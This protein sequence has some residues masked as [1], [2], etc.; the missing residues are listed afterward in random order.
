MGLTSD[1]KEWRD[2]ILGDVQRMTSNVAAGIRLGRVVDVVFV[3]G[4]PGTPLTVGAH[5][6]FR[7]GLNGPAT[8][9]SWAMG[10]TVVGV[11]T[12]GAITV[13]LLAGASLSSLAS[14]CGGAPP[15]LAGTVEQTEVLPTAA[16]TVALPDPSWLMASVTAAD[17]VL[18]EVG[19]TLRVSVDPRG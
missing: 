7:I 11:P 14:L 4:G 15:A 3:L 1:L 13:D 2:G 17:G 10:A 9:L 5:V 19:L 18:E 8:I 16:W 6:F 12:S